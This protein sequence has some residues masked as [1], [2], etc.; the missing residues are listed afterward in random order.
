MGCQALRSVR[1]TQGLQW[2]PPCVPE[3][4]PGTGQY[5]TVRELRGSLDQKTKN[6]KTKPGFLDSQGLPSSRSK[7]PA[8][9]DSR[10]VHPHPQGQPGPHGAHRGSLEGTE[11]RQR[12]AGRD[13]AQPGGSWRRA[14]EGAG[15]GLQVS[16]PLSWLVRKLPGLA[17]G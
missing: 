4:F 16:P 13:A 8:F 2:L 3:P 11:R 5:V 1:E 15:P 9:P 14:Q 6:K 12:Q 17:G 10:R 7:P